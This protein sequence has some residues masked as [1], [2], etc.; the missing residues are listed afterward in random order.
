MGAIAVV[1]T[2]VYLSLQIR[3]SNL[4]SQTVAI[5]RFDSWDSISEVDRDF[6][7]VMRKGYTKR[8]AEISRDEK[9]ELHFHWADYLAK[10]HTMSSL[11]AP[12]TAVYAE[13]S[14]HID[15]ELPRSRC[16]CPRPFFETETR[17]VVPAST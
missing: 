9:A 11:R 17:V 1:V 13:V 10:L 3:R 2:L 8:W 12:T 15:A 7:A 5:Q 6:I 16:K 14:L 4:V